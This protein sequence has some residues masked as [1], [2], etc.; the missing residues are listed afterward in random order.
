MDRKIA[1]WATIGS[2]AAGLVVSAYLTVLSFGPPSTCPVGDFA[3]FSC[4]D[5]IWSKYAYLYGFSVAMLGLGWFVIALALAVLGRNN[6]RVLQGLV[7]W[8]VLGALGVAGFVYTE[9]FLLGRIC[10]LCTIAHV[11]GLATL[12]FSL[13]SLRGNRAIKA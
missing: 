7:V 8:S 1:S 12:V 10:V 13:A 3:I 11:M 6:T 5:V 4:N 2:A 9:V